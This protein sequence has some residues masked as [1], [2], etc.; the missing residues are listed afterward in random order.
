MIVSIVVAIAKNDVIGRGE[1]I[2][3]KIPGEQIRFKELTWNKTILMGRKTYES[4]GK[5]LPNR[6]NIVISR[7][8]GL[9]LSDAIVVK[10]LEEAFSLF[11]KEEELFVIG[12]GQIYEKTLPLAHKLYLTVLDEEISGDIYFPKFDWD[13][14]EKTFEQRVDTASIPYTYY[15]LEKK[16]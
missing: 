8:D 4:I 9:T 14:Y 12:G 6:R 13:R 11:Q 2:P 10:T 7:R 16:R 15:T 5:A 1:D 3:W